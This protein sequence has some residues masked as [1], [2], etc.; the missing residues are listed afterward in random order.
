M[1]LTLSLAA[2]V[3]LPFVARAQD[4]NEALEK[5]IKDAVRKV[6]PTVVQIV[7]QGGADLVVTTPKGPTFRKTLGPT[8]GVIVSEDGYIISSTFNFVNSPTSIL[9]SI[10]GQNEPVV[11]K[12]IAND[13]SR[14]LTLLKVDAKG[15]PVPTA[16]SKKDIVEGQ[17]AIAL[18]RTLDSKKTSLPSVSVG[19]ISAVGRIW[20]KA[21]QTDAKISPV[22]YGGPLIDIQGRV[23]GILI[24]ASPQGDDVTAGFEWYDSGIGFAI[25]FEDV[26]ASLPRLK[27]GKDLEKGIVG[28]RFKGNDIYSVQPEVMQVNKDSPADKAGLKAGDQIVEIDGHPVE[29]LAQIQHLLGV[30]YE[31][32]KIALKYK[33]GKDVVEVKDL[34][35]VGSLQ[36][37]AHPFLGILP[38]RDDPRLGVEIRHV[39]AKSPAEKAGL[40]PGERILKIGVDKS[41]NPLSGVKAGRDELLDILNLLAPGN[42]V[43]LEIQDKAGKT[44][45]VTVSLDPLPGSVAGADWQVPDKIAG[46]ASFGKAHEPLEKIKGK[47]DDKA[48][49]LKPKAK[50]KG[51]MLQVENPQDTPAKEGQEKE[52]KK[53][54]PRKVETGF[55]IRATADG[56]HKYWVY[57]PKKY[58]DNIAHGVLVWLHPPGRNKEAD[59]KEFVEEWE[60]IAEDNHLILVAP[61]SDNADGWIASESDFVTG[62]VREVAKHCTTDPQRI[63]AHGMGVGGQMALHLGMNNRDLF[64]GVLTVGAVPSV[65]KDNQAQQ[66][67]GFY[68]VGGE[69]DPLIKSIADARV[70]LAEKRYSAVF[71]EMPN[72]GREYLTEGLLREAARWIETLDKQ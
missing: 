2:L 15:L 25:P 23:Q 69:L 57:I 8:T 46:P 20:G 22:N 51:G 30:K 13:K 12:R 66:R 11:A 39:F 24:P 10:P 29:R 54:A 14:L 6:A 33:R 50:D 3:L 48:K 27:D 31:G 34:V 43:R 56:E 1:R 52:D 53:A 42:E 58:D 61:K 72:R 70:K 41:L 60:A 47:D 36:V 37:A 63:V 19:I 26:L 5:A 64:R 4:L 49:F 7:T 28:V 65:M 38:L 45:E 59:I 67:L 35:L 16:A 62:A 18:G 9:V 68:L 21:L 55:A 32:D 71:R 44:R 40:V 17:T